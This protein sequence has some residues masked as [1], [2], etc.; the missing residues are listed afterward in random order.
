MTQT[1]MTRKGINVSNSTSTSENPQPDSFV[2]GTPYFNLTQRL[3]HFYATRGMWINGQPHGELAAM[4]GPRAPFGAVSGV[5]FFVSEHQVHALMRDIAEN[6][7]RGLIV[8]QVTQTLRRLR[9]SL[10]RAGRRLDAERRLDAGLRAKKAEDGE[11]AEHPVPLAQSVP[12]PFKQLVAPT[13]GRA[14]A[15]FDKHVFDCVRAMVDYS[16][17]S[18]YE[19]GGY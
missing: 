1:P 8:H 17:E 5:T 14:K 6:G 15:A 10:H 11:T 4:L 18:V 13:N 9:E 16:Q 12:R 7:P 19:G 3:Q 2:V